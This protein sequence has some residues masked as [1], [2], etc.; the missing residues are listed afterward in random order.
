LTEITVALIGLAG[1]CVTA[2]VAWRRVNL[3]RRKTLLAEKELKLQSSALSLSDFLEDWQSVAAA[4]SDLIQNTEIDRILILRA[5]NGYLSPKWTTAVYQ[6]REYGQAPKQYVHT[7]L[8]DDYVERLRIITRGGAICFRVVDAPDSLIK[9]IYEAEGVKAS[10]WWHISTEK[11]P[12]TDAAVIT[13]CS[14]ST[15]SNEEISEK[16]RT[17]CN[18]LVGRLKGLSEVFGIN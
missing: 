3:E 1:I 10:C 13:Y 17:S 14:F 4:M 8:D 9:S 5:W 15:H 7:G 6:M 12:D 11:V 2:G 16:T 18:L